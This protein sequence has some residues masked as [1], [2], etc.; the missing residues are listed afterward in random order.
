MYWLS[1]WLTGWWANAHART[2]A[3]VPS[4]RLV[5]WVNTCVCLV[6]YGRNNNAR[7]MLN[8]IFNISLIL[9]KAFI[10][11]PLKF[12]HTHTQYQN[13]FLGCFWNFGFRTCGF[14][15]LF[16]WPYFDYFMYAVVVD[17]FFCCLFVIRVMVVRCTN[18]TKQRKYVHKKGIILATGL[19]KIRTNEIWI[20]CRQNWAKHSKPY[21]FHWKWQ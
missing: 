5:D 3:R 10:S 9:S 19:S 21:A 2:F 16:V 20:W 1:G 17:V 4:S 18:E 15:P 8:S 12:K 6:I 13:H 11:C 14:W 7:E